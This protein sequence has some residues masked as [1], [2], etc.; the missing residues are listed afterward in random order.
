MLGDSLW[1]KSY[2]H[3][4]RIKTRRK[5]DFLAATIVPRPLR[6]GRVTCKSGKCVGKCVWLWYLKQGDH[7]KRNSG[8]IQAKRYALQPAQQ[9][10]QKWLTKNGKRSVQLLGSV[11]KLS[12]NGLLRSSFKSWSTD[13][14]TAIVKLYD[15]NLPNGTHVRFICQQCRSREIPTLVCVNSF[16]SKWY[17]V[18]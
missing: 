11:Y 10:C 12:R 14:L 15:W 7:I 18:L 13:A 6:Y 9:L 5:A 4:P 3:S 16:D 1:E 2:P 17:P 8:Q